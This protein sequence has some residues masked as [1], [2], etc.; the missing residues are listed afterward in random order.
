MIS[1]N[2]QSAA[3]GLFAALL[4]ACGTSP[5]PVVPAASQLSAAAIDPGNAGGNKFVTV[6]SQNLYLGAEL[7]PAM[8]PGLSDFE[9]LQATTSIWQMVNRND[10]GLRARGVADEIAAQRPELVGLQEAYTWKFRDAAVAPEDAVVVYDYV[11]QLI[12][13]LAARG[14]TYRVAASVALFDFE[15]PIVKSLDPFQVAFIRTTDHGVILAREDVM[16]VRG[17]GH[18]YST[19]L[20]ISVHGQALSIPRGWVNVD[21]KHQGEWFTFASTHLEAF[22][23]VVRALQAQELAA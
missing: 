2:R 18:T 5:A 12:A 4:V 14:V 17:E 3:F 1:V 23:P 8:Q 21:V 15:A 10:F 9:F 13:Q 11:S 16:T 20:P 22:H 6:M 7:A 19:E